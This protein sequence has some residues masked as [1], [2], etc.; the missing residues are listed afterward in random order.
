MAKKFKAVSKLEPE[1]L[2]EIS[3]SY[4]GG[5]CGNRLGSV[6]PSSGYN[7]LRQ[8]HA[9]FAPLEDHTALCQRSTPIIMPLKGARDEAAG[10]TGLL[11]APR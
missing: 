8:G 2:I 1:P 9:A 7:A 4:N 10:L 5:A 6:A 3:V 11:P